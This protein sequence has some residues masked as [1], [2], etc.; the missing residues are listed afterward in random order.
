MKS[1]QL[2]HNQPIIVSTG[3][4][5]LKITRRYYS[6]EIE[7]AKEGEQFFRIQLQGADYCHVFGGVKYIQANQELGG[8]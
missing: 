5:Q 2:E 4:T 1:I 3:K 6:I 8:D 7:S